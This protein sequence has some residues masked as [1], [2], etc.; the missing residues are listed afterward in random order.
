ML[1]SM[2]PRKQTP[3]ADP[4]NVVGYVRVSTGDQADSGLGMAAQRSAIEAE[5]ERRGWTVIAWAEDAGASAKSMANR[6]GLAAAL[7]AIEAGEAAGLVVAKLDRLSRSLVDFASLM[8]RAAN[9]GW[10]VVALDLGIDLGTPAGRFL[11]SVMA[12]AA[13][14]E[15]EIIGQ[16]TRD[17]L[18]AKKAA[19]ATL[20]RPRA[21]PAEVRAR[22]MAARSGGASFA[23]IARHLEAEGVPTAQGGARWWPSTVRNIATGDR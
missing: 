13:E 16:R 7:E 18:A 22:I 4:N 2:A 23:A 15:R 6:P 5:A 12:S 1:P 17:A 10:N 21:L 11:A 14:W 9:D 19:G 8:A 20:G 3:K